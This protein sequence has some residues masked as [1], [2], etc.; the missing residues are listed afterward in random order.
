MTRSVTLVANGD[1]RESANVKCWPAQEEMEKA[2]AGALARFGAGVARAHPFKPELGHG[3][4][5]TQREGIEVF[6]GI[7]PDAPLIVAE[8]VW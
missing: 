8:A 2:L 5:A 4:I 3:F 7:D 1:L 6:A